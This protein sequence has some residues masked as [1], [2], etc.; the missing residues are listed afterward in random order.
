MKRMYLKRGIFK[1]A[2]ILI[3]IIWKDNFL[4]YDNRKLLIEPINQITKGDR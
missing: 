2:L 4:D 1:E 3:Q